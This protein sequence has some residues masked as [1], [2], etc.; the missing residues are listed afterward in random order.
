MS[1]D[2]LNAGSTATKPGENDKSC[3]ETGCT[4]GACVEVI[5][6]QHFWLFP[7][8]CGEQGIVLQHC[9]ASS[10]VVMAPQSVVY[11]A[12]ANAMAI[13]KTGFAKRIPPKL[14]AW[15]VEVKASWPGPL[16]AWCG[17]LTLARGVG[18]FPYSREVMIVVFGD[19][20]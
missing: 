12:V 3:A 11:A 10:G 19:K 8:L 6:V 13:S 5:V 9:I 7:W 14:C 17:C 1:C 15:S 2:A 18:Q 16:G 4:N 20:I